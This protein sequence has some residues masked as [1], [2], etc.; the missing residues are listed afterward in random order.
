VERFYPLPLVIER[1]GAVA[2]TVELDVKGRATVS[3]APAVVS[4]AHLK[5]LGEWVEAFL[6]KV[7]TA[8][9]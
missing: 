3:V 8:K 7:A 4:A 5:T 1:Q 6:T 9:H 2:A